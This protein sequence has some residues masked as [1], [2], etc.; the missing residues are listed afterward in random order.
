[1]D[2]LAPCVGA[3]AIATVAAV[4]SVDAAVKSY[5]GWVMRNAR[6]SASAPVAQVFVRAR[7][8]STSGI[9]VPTVCPVFA[10]AVMVC[11]VCAPEVWADMVCVNV[12]P[13][14]IEIRVFAVV[15]SESAPASRLSTRAAEDRI[16]ISSPSEAAVPV[17]DA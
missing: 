17:S 2:A 13:A 9:S 15:P 3:P 16:P 12:P 14:E 6:W 5:V 10:A 8:K 11:M 1:M 7:S 4:V